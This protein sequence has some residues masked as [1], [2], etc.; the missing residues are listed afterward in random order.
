ML[1]QNNFCYDSIN[2]A[3]FNSLDL[4]YEPCSAQKQKERN[5]NYMEEMILS[6][7]RDF[8]SMCNFDYSLTIEQECSL[9]KTVFIMKIELYI[10]SSEQH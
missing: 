3:I 2:Q 6:E 1:L 7:Y 4:L 9:K 10:S 5:T 8:I